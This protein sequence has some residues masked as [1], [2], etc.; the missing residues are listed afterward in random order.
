MKIFLYA[1]AALT[2]LALAVFGFERLFVEHT[3]GPAAVAS[4]AVLTVV[5]LATLTLALIYERQRELVGNIVLAAVST[6]VT[7]VLV[8]LAAGFFL[9]QRLSPPLVADQYVH[10]RMVPSSLSSFSQQD[11]HYVQR[12]NNLGMRGDDVVVAKPAKT[13]RI[14]TLGDSFTMGKGVQD[15]ETFSVLLQKQLREQ[16]AAC[17]AAPT[18]EVLNGGV[19]SYAPILSYLSLT[20]TLGQLSPDVII[21]NLDVSDLVQETAYRQIATRDS[22]G[23]ITGVPQAERSGSMTER[24]RDWT[25][26][27][28]FITRALIF[29]LIERANYRDLTVRSVVEQANAE[30]AAHTLAEDTEPRDEQWGRIFESLGMM[31]QYADDH[32]AAFYLTVYPWGHQVSYKEWVPGRSAFMTADQHPSDKSRFTVQQMGRERGITVIDLFPA[33]RAYHGGQPLYFAHDMHW[34]AAGHQVT[35]AALAEQLLPSFKERWCH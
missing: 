27:H 28:L 8:D 24:I 22:E 3:L 14:L 15:H 30:I 10:H 29:Y 25:E 20:R 16:L 12:V 18:V 13:F 7:Y 2:G 6:V 33:F 32:Q 26:R 4:L 23:H 34:T 9:I 19:D 21:E 5:F 17:P 31:K 1:A 11:F 35:A